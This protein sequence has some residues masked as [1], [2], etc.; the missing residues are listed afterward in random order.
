MRRAS[1]S[2]PIA[3]AGLAAL[4]AAMGIGRFIYTP[5]LPRMVEAGELTNADAGLLASANFA[6]YLVGALLAATPAIGRSRRTWLFAGLIASSLTTG[7]M[8]F[9]AGVE[10]F[11]VVRFIGGVASAIVLVLASALVLER[12]T[13]ANRPGLSALYFAGVGVGIV[14][15]ALLVFVISESRADWRALWLAGGIVALV[16]S[17]LAAVPLLGPASVPHMPL[18]FEGPDRPRRA[19]LRP[20]IAA[21]GLFGFGY[22]IT[23]TF[24]VAIVRGSAETRILE[25]T[26]W[27]V[28]GLAAIPSVA[29]WG[30]LARRIGVPRAI[31]LACLVEAIGVSFTVLGASGTGVLIGGALLGGTFMGITALGLVRAR[32]EGADP[33][34]IV[35]IMTGAFGVGQIVGPTFAGV[36]YDA[37]GTLWLPTLAAA[38]ALVLAAA[39]ASR[40]G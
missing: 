28:V 8:A 32:A 5:I 18:T 30:L 22:V 20:L 19:D 13:A 34:R 1:A 2:F 14:A 9:A 38:A 31:A 11:A 27:L 3:L 21:Y 37:S 7:A 33:R 29:L 36:L 17:V 40:G 39:L 25:A 26:V 16:G 24:L 35:A 15:S 4:A 23:A 10:T 6:G 12:L